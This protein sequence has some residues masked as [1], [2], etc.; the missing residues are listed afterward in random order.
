MVFFF[1]FF[2]PKAQPARWLVWNIPKDVPPF[3]GHTDLAPAAPK[4]RTRHLGSCDQRSPAIPAERYG[5]IKYMVGSGSPV[6][7]SYVGQ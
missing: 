2:F 4:S 7:V 5:I 1:F 6:A 3:R